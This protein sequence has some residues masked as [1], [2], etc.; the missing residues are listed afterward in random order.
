MDTSNAITQQ[1]RPVPPRAD[2]RN[3]DIKQTAGKCFNCGKAGHFARE[4]PDNKP[5]YNKQ[6]SNMIMQEGS[7]TQDDTVLIINE[8]NN[9]QTHRPNK[10]LITFMGLVSDQPAYVLIDS[11]ATNNYISESFVKK[12]GLYTEPSAEVAQAVLADGTTLSVTRMS[13]SIPI[14]IQEYVDVIDANVLALDKYDL[15]LS[16]AWLDAYAPSVDYRSKTV[17]FKHDGKAITLKPTSIDN[18]AHPST[19]VPTMQQTA[20]AEHDDTPSIDDVTT[21]TYDRMLSL[22]VTTINDTITPSPTPIQQVLKQIPDSVDKQAV[23]RLVKLIDQHSDIFPAELP[24][25]IPE[26]IVMHEIEFK[27]D[28]KPIKQR[29]Y[30]LAPKYLPFVKQTIDMLVSK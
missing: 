26:H 5:Q 28:A 3:N 22:R 14:H 8:I 13:P 23:T 6:R 20:S 16:I 18:D 2:N 19:T 17:S 15:V 1:R 24:S 30:P 12:H 27:P 4:C 21:I 10:K 7:V 11:G 25:G 9:M 29:P